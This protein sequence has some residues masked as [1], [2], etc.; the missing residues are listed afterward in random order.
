MLTNLIC[1]NC[2]RNAGMSTRLQKFATVDE[3]VNVTKSAP[4]GQ[5]SRP[6][7]IAVFRFRHGLV[8]VQIIHDCAQIF[9]SARQAFVGEIGPRQQELQ[10]LTAYRLLEFRQQRLRREF[11][12]LQINFEMQVR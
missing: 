12:R 6:M 4:F 9:Q 10:V 11:V 7:T 8:G 1:G 2:A 5:Q 3:L